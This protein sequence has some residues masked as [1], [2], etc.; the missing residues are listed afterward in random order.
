M[1]LKKRNTQT[2]THTQT[3]SL[4]PHIILSFF[5]R[6]WYSGPPFHF[7]LLFW[8][9]SNLEFISLLHLW[10]SEGGGYEPP[11]NIPPSPKSPHPNYKAKMLIYC[12]HINVKYV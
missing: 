3:P 5:I 8:M 10:R 12:I 11:P 1:S 6:R 7:N 2:E 9:V 4:I